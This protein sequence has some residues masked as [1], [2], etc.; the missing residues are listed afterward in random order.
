MSLTNMHERDT[1]AQIIGMAKTLDIIERNHL[2]NSIKQ[3][4][5]KKIN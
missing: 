4:L 1:L 2:D 3:S 5:Q